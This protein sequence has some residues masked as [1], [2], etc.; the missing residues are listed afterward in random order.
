MDRI[1][2]QIPGTAIGLGLSAFTEARDRG[3]GLLEVLADASVTGAVSEDIRVNL[4]YRV[5]PA[6]SNRYG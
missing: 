6:N 1:H 5:I 3:A 2:A 4:P